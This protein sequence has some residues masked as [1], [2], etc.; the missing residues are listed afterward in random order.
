MAPRA[1]AKRKRHSGGTM[2]PVVLMRR[3]GLPGRVLGTAHM[4]GDQLVEIIKPHLD[5][6]LSVNVLPFNA[7]LLPYLAAKAYFRKISQ[8]AI[9]I[10]I[11]SAARGLELRHIELLKRRGAIVGLDS[12]DSPVSD[13]DFDLFDFHIAAS[14]AGQEAIRG[15][16]Q[17]IGRPDVPVELLYHH[18]DPRLGF[19]D[20]PGQGTFRCGYVGLPDNTVIPP[21]IAHEIEVVPIKYAADFSAGIER[22]RSFTLHYGVRPDLQTGADLERSFKPFTKGVTAASSRSNILVD[23]FVDDAVTLLGEDYP[24]LVQSNDPE[25][26][27]EIFRK[28]KEGFGGPD[29]IQGLERMQLMQ[30][31]VSPEALAKRL[32]DITDKVS[33]L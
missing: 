4:R 15:K 13:I 24:Y 31:M 19:V 17:R 22:I 16:L 7:D 28:A 23:R 6:S 25:A 12:V 9:V 10:F 21:D 29:W 27:T 32:R 2:R 8:H 11:K 5:D 1:L 26:V 33:E 3:M 18:A 30:Q 20:T 14:M